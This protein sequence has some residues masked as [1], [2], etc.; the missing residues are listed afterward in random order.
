VA[1]NDYPFSLRASTDPYHIIGYTAGGS[2]PPL[3]GDTD[4]WIF[5]ANLIFAVGPNTSPTQVMVLRSNASLQLP[6][7]ANLPGS[8]TSD[9][10]IDS[11]GNVAPQTS[12][13]RFKENVEPLTG[14]FHKILS[15][16]P[17]SFTYRESGQRAIG[18][19]AEDLHDQDLRDLVTYDQ[20]GNPLSIQYKLLP[21]YMLELLKEQKATIDQLAGEVAELKANLDVKPS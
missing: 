16:E 9:L 12:S 6:A 20:E 7:M 19:T 18:Y 17:K 15:L 21:I 11:Q 2:T 5:N 4:F 13:V 1:V 8:G 14:D 3:P 10:T